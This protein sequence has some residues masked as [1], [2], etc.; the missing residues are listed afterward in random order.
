MVIVVKL[1]GSAITYKNAYMK[2][3]IEVIRRVSGEIRKFWDET[4]GREKIIIVHGGGSFGHP[5]AK[6]YNLHEGLIHPKALIGVSE[7]VDVMRILSLILSRSMREKGLPIFPLQTSGVALKRGGRVDIFY[8]DIIKAALSKGFIP[9]L[10]GDVV[11]D[12]EKGA[13]IIS[14][15]E[16]I[17]EISK[18]IR[19]SRVIFGTDV[20]G[21]YKDIERREIYRRIS[22]E[23]IGEVFERIFKASPRDVTGGMKAK[24]EIC[25]SLAE[26]GINVQII[27]ILKPNYLLRALRGEVVGTII[28]S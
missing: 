4:R 15:D 6:K 7:T 22:L 13:S 23:N 9:L 14:G 17:L 26:K 27:N 24:L 10:W 2:P 20:D 18:Q 5:Q 1:G 28:E 11:L 21:V 16:I 8:T 19:V 12:H 25:L 3:R